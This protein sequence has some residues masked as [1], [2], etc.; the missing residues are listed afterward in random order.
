[1]K[2]VPTIDFSGLT[3]TYN[4]GAHLRE[5][6]RSQQFCR[7]IIVVDLG[8]TDGSAEL[9]REMG[10][11]VVAHDWVPVVEEVRE[12]A[13]RQASNEWI[14]F[15]DPDMAVAAEWVDEVHDIIAQQSD[16]GA[17]RAPFQNYFLGRPLTVTRWGRIS[18][19]MLFFHRERVCLDSAVHRGMQVKGG[20]RTVTIQPTADNV[21]PHYWV[22]SWRE[23]F[24]KHERYLALEGKAL[25]Q[26]GERFSYR[27]LLLEPMKGLYDSFIVCRGIAGGFRGWA[28]S[29]YWGYYLLRRWW[30]LRSYRL[31]QVREGK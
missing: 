6:L 15:V 27:S 2:Q 29:L 16:V 18:L 14:V 5:C 20:F 31:E 26:T 23:F 12:F 10:A 4:S 1:M 22:D 11:R 13:V 30:G 17:I 24:A 7:E 21:M 28:L 9:A 8:S 3:V 25:C 19:Y